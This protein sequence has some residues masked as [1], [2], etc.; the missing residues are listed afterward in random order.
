[1]ATTAITY[2]LKIDSRYTT[3]LAI[4]VPTVEVSTA[5]TIFPTILKNR[6]LLKR[7]L[8]K[9]LAVIRPKLWCDDVNHFY[10]LVTLFKF[11][12]LRIL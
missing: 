8:L 7:E 10:V 1:M 3:V 6:D 2:F 12:R 5:N 9:Y 4:M 11:S